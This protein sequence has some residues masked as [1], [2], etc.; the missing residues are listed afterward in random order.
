MFGPRAA[1]LRAMDFLAGLRRSLGV[2][3][4]HE[5]LCAAFREWLA[6]P[7]RGDPDPGRSFDRARAGWDAPRRS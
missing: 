1:R 3:D 5:T 6:T 4:D 2:D 7:D